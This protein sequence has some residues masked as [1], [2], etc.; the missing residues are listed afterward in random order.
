VV[1]DKESVGSVNRHGI[2]A[3]ILYGER[4]LGLYLAKHNNKES[5]VDTIS[6][7]IFTLICC[8]V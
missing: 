3:K 7:L 8:I 5:T 2:G 1:V 6:I 4:A